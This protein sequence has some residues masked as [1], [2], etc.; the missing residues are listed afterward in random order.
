MTE[1]D[2]AKHCWE[3][4]PLTEDGCSTTCFLL[5]GHEGQHEWTRDDEIIISFPPQAAEV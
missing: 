1:P 2:T 5:D 3:N 4:G